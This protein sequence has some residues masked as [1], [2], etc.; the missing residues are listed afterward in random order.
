M[1]KWILLLSCLPLFS[2]SKIVQEEKI[3]LLHCPSSI[4]EVSGKQVGSFHRIETEEY[5]FL[6]EKKATLLLYVLASGCQTCDTFGFLLKSYIRDTSYLIEM[7][8]MD[9]F[10]KSQHSL[11]LSDSSLVFIKEG[12]IIDYRSSFENLGSK[13]E[14]SEYLSDK[15]ED[16]HIEILNKTEENTSIASLDSYRFLSEMD[17]TQRR[18]DSSILFIKE[19][20][21]LDYS[22]IISYSSLNS[23]SYLVFNQEEQE[24]EN[25]YLET[26]VKI[27]YKNGEAIA[28][29]F[30]SLA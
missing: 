19:K 17:E 15:V 13:K 29:P 5:D 12:K 21:A 25:L 8:P 9:S 14:L 16:S 23:I 11:S 28:T 27:E 22:E 6:M 3:S 20:K 30:D 2:C 18:N 7:M 24:I 4:K 10:L 26:Y 1:K